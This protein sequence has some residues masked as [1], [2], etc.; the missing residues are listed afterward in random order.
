MDTIYDLQRRAQELADAKLEGS[1]TPQDVGGL[2]LDTLAY[3]AGMEQRNAGGLG[4]RK[5]YA[6]YE[7]MQADQQPVG[8]DGHA[9]KFGQ[10]AVIATT[11]AGGAHD[12]EIYAYQNPGWVHI[13]NI[14]SNG[15]LDIVQT[16]GSSKEVVMS[17]KAV[18]DELSTKA[19]VSVVELLTKYVTAPFDEQITDASILSLSVINYDKIVYVQSQKTFVAEYLGKYYNNW[20]GG[21]RPA[22]LYLDDTRRNPLRNKIY[23]CQGK[24]YAFEGADGTLTEICKSAGS[25]GGGSGDTAALEAR[26]SKVEETINELKSLLLMAAKYNK[27]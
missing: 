7:A 26:L 8:T 5:T 4:L 3:I 19:N 18:T 9:L 24:A 21:D 15:S 10:L 13:G 11:P 1:I 12:G 23:I 27:K 25:S 20:A 6:T 2:H 16:T 22:D 17:Q 14:N